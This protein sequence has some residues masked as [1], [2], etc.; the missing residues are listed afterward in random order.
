MTV[1]PPSFNEL[2]RRV[3]VTT[4]TRYNAAQ[5]LNSHHRF[6]Q[7]VVTLVSVAL[8]AIPLLQAMNVPLGRSPQLLDAVEVFL[9]VLVLAYSLLLGNENYS[10]KAEKMLNCG[11]ELGR[12][13]RRLYP[14]LDQPHQEDLY[15][16]FSEEY[17][18][19][20]EKYENH[21][22]IDYE[23]YRISNPRFYYKNKV[24]HVTAWISVKLKYY[25]GYWHYIMVIIGVL[26]TILYIFAF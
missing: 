13:S 11:L 3:D 16:E 20:L 18:D 6:S 12:L 15:K 5:R 1:R 26:F 10:G 2:Y 8:I 25:L 14:H 9:A 19:I 21:D 17:H 23:M 4:R 22:P 7:W 24:A